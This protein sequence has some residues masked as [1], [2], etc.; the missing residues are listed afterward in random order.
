MT[1]P[2]PLGSQDGLFAQ[3]YSTPSPQTGEGEQ[4]DK[5]GVFRNGI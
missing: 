5:I 2:R 4:V 3:L 1:S